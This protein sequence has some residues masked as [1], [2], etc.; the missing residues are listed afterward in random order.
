[1]TAID[2]GPLD[3]QVALAGLMKRN[4]SYYIY[5]GAFLFWSFTLSMFLITLWDNIWLV[6]A[7][8]LLLG[9]LRLQWA[10]LGHDFAHLQVFK[11]QKKN[12]FFA[13]LVWGTTCWAS[14]TWWEH[15]HNTH[16]KN[17]NQVWKDPDVEIPFAFDEKLITGKSFFYRKLFLPYQHLFLFPWLPTTFVTGLYSSTRW[18]I[19]NF[20]IKTSLESLLIIAS[21]LWMVFLSF[22]YLSLTNA[23]IFLLWNLVV[24]GIYMGILFF[25]NHYGETV[26]DAEKRYERLYQVI[27]SRNISGKAITD[28]LFWGLNLQ[29]EHHLYPTMPRANLPKVKKMVK[30]FCKSQK[31]TYHEV[32]ILVAFMEMFLALRKVAKRSTTPQIASMEVPSIEILTKEI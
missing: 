32:N 5:M 17:T 12:R 29:I 6:L 31:V 18:I 9:F 2:F 30:E 24:S 1:M 15:Q 25:P 8:T 19:K 14:G 3:K 16:H 7:N 10:L 27:T 11:W 26:I 21:I 22:Y 20:S 23:L 4:Y 28:F 13:S